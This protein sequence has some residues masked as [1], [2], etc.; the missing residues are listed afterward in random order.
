MEVRLAG[1]TDGWMDG[2]GWMDALLESSK[3]F[4]HDSRLFRAVES[5]SEL[6]STAVMP[7]AV[8]QQNPSDT[9]LDCPL[10]TRVRKHQPVWP[11]SQ[12]GEDSSRPY[13]YLSQDKGR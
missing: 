1:W 4:R 13:N 3:L 12:R 6:V 11:S 5:P 10:M 9:K 7:L 2:N 8:Y